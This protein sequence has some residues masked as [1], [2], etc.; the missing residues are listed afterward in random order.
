MLSLIKNSFIIF[1][2][3]FFWQCNHVSV[4]NES[5]TFHIN[6]D[7]VV[8]TASSFT[9]LT[10]GM[11]PPFLYQNAEKIIAAEYNIKFISVAGCIINDRLSDS[12]TK[13][14]ENSFAQL[15]AFYKRDVLTEIYPK[16][17]KEAAHLIKLDSV[18]MQKPEMKRIALTSTA[19]KSYHKTGRNYSAYFVVSEQNKNITEKEPRAWLQKLKLVVTCDSLGK[20]IN[21]ISPK[22]SLVNS[23]YDF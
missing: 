12:I 7:S 8:Q 23:L 13:F 19:Y 15:K 21:N 5:G 3:L 14:N 9:I 4:S 20:T 16:I 22:D 1:I 17:E 11:P 10:A 18:L 6:K 2:C